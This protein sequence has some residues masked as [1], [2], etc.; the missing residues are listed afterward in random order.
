MAR[1]ADSTVGPTILE[2]RSVT[3][4]ALALIAFGCLMLPGLSTAGDTRHT[5][6]FHA[7]DVSEKTFGRKLDLADPSGKNRRLD[8]FRG[9]V[10][11]VYFGFTHCP[12][13]C[14]TELARLAE[15]RRRLG[16]AGQRVQVLFVTLDPERDSAGLLREYVSAFDPGFIALRG[17]ATS[18][19]KAAKE[20][21]VAYLKIPG[22]APDRYTLDH[23]SYVYALDPDSRLRLRFD[24]AISIEKML[25]DVMM[26]IDER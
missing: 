9:N 5:R 2:R 12:D 11:L 17:S 15:L 20:F 22:S 3:R 8:E 14:P 10:V 24:S 7:E 13:V 25:A 1:H 18:T 21:R 6:S 19:A 23:S 16:P 4:L 26:L